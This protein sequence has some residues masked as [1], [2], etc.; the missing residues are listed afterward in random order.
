[1]K[2]IPNRMCSVCRCRVPKNQ[3]FR[4]N[5]LKNGEIMISD[6]KLP[7]SR[8]LYICKNAECIDK[9]INKKILNKILKCNI[10]NEIYEELEKLKRSTN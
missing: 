5:L 3:L 9:L 10:K 2:K 7:N 4:I 1:M 6:D 8:G